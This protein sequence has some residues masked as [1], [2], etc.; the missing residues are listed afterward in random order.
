MTTDEFAAKIKAKYPAYQ[1][2]DN[3]TLTQ[4][5]IAKYPVYASQ[6]DQAPVPQDQPSQI[7]SDVKGV[8]GDNT[9][10]KVLTGIG[11]FGAGVGSAVMNAGL[12][13][14]QTALKV[15]GRVAPNF[16][17]PLIN[18]ASNALDKTKQTI[19]DVYTPET[20]SI[21]GKLGTVGGTIA[22][23][24]APSSEI[25]N[26][27]NFAVNS[28]KGAGFLPSAGRVLAGAGTEGALNYAQGY[29]LSGGDTNAAKTQGLTAGVLKGATGTLG[30]VANSLNVPEA[31]N[32]KVFKTDKKEVQAI[33]AGNQEDSLAKQ[34]LD[35]GIAGNT[36][37]IATQLTDGMASSEQKISQAFADAGNPNITLE[38][39]KRFLDYLQ[40]KAELLRKSGAIK[41][42][43]G[44]EASIPAINPQTGEIT[45]NNA[46]AL[47]RFLDGLR[48]EKSYQVPTEELTA[49]QAG[50]KEM[51]DEIRHKINAIG[52]TGE[53]M[54]DY[55]FYI[56]AMDKLVSHAVR[57]KN[58]DAIGL[59]NSFLLGDAVANSHPLLG[60]VAVGRR[61]I[62]ST[63]GATKGAQAL[64][65]LTQSGK[66]GTAIR[67]VAGKL[68][69]PKK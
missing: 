57:T 43:Q 29:A 42:A 64:K 2:L 47:R 21:P 40:N 45:A 34:V 38:E 41:E 55:S 26:T 17:Q 62:G 13:L 35:R 44:L 24:S 65:N 30:E 58:N 22:A 46:L 10:G 33:F 61:F 36:K 9:V 6:I 7:A 19:S 66:T 3:A 52:G 23:Y 12:G 69:S 28:I 31:L 18:K 54:K 27:T 25:A 49:Q 59:I 60:A 15:A 32:T 48:Y 50:L 20:K 37:Q 56:K 11:Q 51:S 4:K 1:S 5:F 63:S 53:A 39:P 16:E 68:I 8:V 14:G 67:S